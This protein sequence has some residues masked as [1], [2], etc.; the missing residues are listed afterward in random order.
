MNSTADMVLAI[1]PVATASDFHSLYLDAVLP[2]YGGWSTASALVGRQIYVSTAAAWVPFS[3]RATR[4]AE[5][6]REQE[7]SDIGLDA[8]WCSIRLERPR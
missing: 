6:T 3:G 5:L 1:Q 8:R 7:E 2:N 4:A